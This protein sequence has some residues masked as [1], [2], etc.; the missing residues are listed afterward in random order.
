MTFPYILMSIPEVFGQNKFWSLE[1][2]SNER[3]T[4]FFE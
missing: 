4:F 1:E 2:I 3:E